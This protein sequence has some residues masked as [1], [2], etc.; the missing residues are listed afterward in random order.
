MSIAYPILSLLLRALPGTEAR[1]ARREY[2][3]FARLRKADVAF[4]SFPKSG[5]TFV[6]AMLAR[7]Y[8]LEFGIDERELLDFATLLRAPR[9]VPRILFTHDNDAMRRPSAIRIHESAYSGRKV[10][11]LA[12]HPGDIVVSRYHHLR[13]RSRDQARRQLAEQPID[14]FV[15]TERGGIPSIVCYLNAWAELAR[16]RGDI[17]IRYEDFNNEPE[18]ALASLAAFI[19][20]C[21]EPSQIADAVNFARLDNLRAREQDGYFSSDRLRARSAGAAQSSKIRSGGSGG[22]RSALEA[23]NAARI[24]QYLDHRLDPVFNYSSKSPAPSSSVQADAFVRAT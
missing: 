1:S 16:R 5:R 13:H 18:A 21:S 20:L 11:L 14:Q 9:A 6:R 22:F 2:R 19:G 3:D 8:Q 24:E 10:V 4:V 7:L 12:R 23:G 17:R 15:W